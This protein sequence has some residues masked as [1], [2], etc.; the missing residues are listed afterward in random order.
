MNSERDP[1]ILSFIWTFGFVTAEAIGLRFSMQEPRV[2]RAMARLRSEGA[3]GYKRLYRQYSGAYFLTRK[4]CRIA[5]LPVMKEP[6]LELVNYRHQLG[7]LMLGVEEMLRN[8]TQVLTERE[9]RLAASEGETWSVRLPGQRS[10]V[11]WPD[12]ALI[13]GTSTVA[14]ELELAAKR[15]VRLAQIIDGYERQSTYSTVRFVVEQ[16][17]V[18]E[19]IA[20]ITAGWR[21]GRSPN[22]VPA[23]RI[24][25]EPWAKAPEPERI[26]RAAERVL[27]LPRQ[28]SLW[29]ELLTTQINQQQ[30]ERDND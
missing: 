12:L 8:G 21:P 4:G 2:Y 30:K 18:A 6:S 22:A 20:R 5:G 15:S 24:Q 13:D 23:S 3:V 14:V 7:V 17:A 28:T 27:E 1:K 29:R 16:G 11:R 26:R 10:A 9:M 25:I 19:R